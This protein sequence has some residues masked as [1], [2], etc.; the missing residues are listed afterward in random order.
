MIC[1]YSLAAEEALLNSSNLVGR[2]GVGKGGQNQ[3]FRHSERDSAQ[4][5]QAD[6][7]AAVAIVDRFRIGFNGWSRSWSAAPPTTPGDCPT[8]W[9]RP[10]ANQSDPLNNSSFSSCGSAITGRTTKRVIAVP[11][12][13]VNI[14]EVI[15]GC[16]DRCSDGQTGFISRLGQCTFPVLSVLC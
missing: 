9:R 1:P 15:L 3:F 2:R 14:V 5:D 4:C 7:A 12:C 11:Q 16:E 10:R 13:I 8:E 6:G